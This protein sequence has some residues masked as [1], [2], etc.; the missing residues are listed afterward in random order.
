MLNELVSELVNHK[1]LIFISDVLQSVLLT[2][3][4]LFHFLSLIIKNRILLIRIECLK[5]LDKRRSDIVSGIKLNWAT[6]NW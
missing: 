5:F 1:F 6:M 2:L 4:I 3:K